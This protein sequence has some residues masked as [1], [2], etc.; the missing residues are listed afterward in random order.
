[1]PYPETIVSLKGKPIKNSYKF[2]YLGAFSQFDDTSIGDAELQNRITSGTCKFFELKNFFSNRKIHLQTRI[3]Y[4]Q[5]LVRSRMTYLCGAW[6][7]TENQMSKM[8]SHY[9]KLIRHMV[10]GGR[11]RSSPIPYT[12]KNGTIGTYSK[13]IITNDQ[14]VKITKIELL[15]VFIKRQ[16]ENWIAHCVRADDNDY[17]KLLTFPDY[18]VGEAKKRGVLNS[19]YRQVWLRHKDKNETENGMLTSFKQK[20]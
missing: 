18:Y 15:S 5:S 2:K 1:M 3:K 8:D 4:L 14:I 16:Q 9:I 12:R 13:P 19:T 11:Q 17:I 7:I 10:K 20:S 6:T